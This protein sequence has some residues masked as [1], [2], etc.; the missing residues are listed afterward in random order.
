MTYR[1]GIIGC[2]QIASVFEDDEWREHP[3]T[4][5]GA[6]N[7]VKE[8]KILAVAD[9]NKDRLSAFSKRWGVKSVYEDY[10]EMLEKEELDIVSV[11]TNTSLHCKITTEAAKSGVKAIFCEKPIATCLE[12]ADK[13]VKI[14]DKEQVK[15]IVNHTRRWDPYYQKA[16]ELIDNEK[17]G[18]LTSITGYFTSGLLIMGTHL[19][20]LFRF[21]SG[22][23]EWVVADS[24]AKIKDA[25]N[26]YQKTDPSGC[27]FVHF[28]NG[29]AG[30]V[31]GSSKKQYLIFEVDIHGTQGRIHI[32]G[33]GRT[34]E[35]WTPDTERKHIS[36]NTPNE[37]I[38]EQISPIERK[39]NMIAAVEDVIRAVKQDSEGMC[40]G[41][42]GRAALEL[43]LAFHKSVQEGGEKIALPLKDRKLRVVSR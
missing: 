27:G 28:K 3:C 8:T 26:G 33:N 9:I 29:I 43:A 42:D 18:D 35:L 20:D 2:G 16:K 32:R 24:E 38:L 21:L 39:N 22:D 10:N 23:V 14:C 36:Y 5:A 12:E 11:T 40:T 15:L 6:Y 4:H 34:F 41:R 25:A 1:V 19:F 37:L 17:I 30:A 13:M 31:L 7:A